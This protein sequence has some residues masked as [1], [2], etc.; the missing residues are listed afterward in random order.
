MKQEIADFITFA[1]VEKGLAANS[2]EA[3]QRDMDRFAAFL[4]AVKVSSLLEV[5][6]K[7][8]SGYVQALSEV[9]LAASSISR[10]FSSIR[11]FY[12]YALMDNLAEQDPTEHLIAP[13]IARTLPDVLSVEEV[14]RI[15][16]A[17]KQ[18][19]PLGLRDRVLLEIIYGAGLRISELISLKIDQVKFQEGYIRVFGKGSKERVVPFGGP[20][21]AALKKYLTEERGRPHLDKGQSE[22]F[23]LLNNRGKKLSRM[24]VWKIIQKYSSAEV[25][26]KDVHPH[27]FRHSFATH[28]LDGGADLRAVQEMLG[29][30]DISTTQ[31]YTHVELSY[32][33]EVHRTF[34]PRSKKKNA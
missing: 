2:I 10:N 13:K 21:A 22:G 5:S 29:H 33:R 3:Y 34:H 12:K 23:L 1:S 7:N 15:I 31:I 18:G 20:A 19:T 30:A 26:E 28:L 8:V 16:E 27:T 11:S 17:P 25:P 4:K 14:G 24:G 32:L 9:G 6:Q